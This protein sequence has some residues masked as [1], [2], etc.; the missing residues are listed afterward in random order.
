[1]ETIVCM[2]LVIG[3]FITY[4]AAGRLRERADRESSADGG[5]RRGLVGRVRDK[6]DMVEHPSAQAPQR[7]VPFVATDGE[8]HG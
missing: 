3:F 7:A 1:M 2:I 8:S 6:R 4:A 5:D